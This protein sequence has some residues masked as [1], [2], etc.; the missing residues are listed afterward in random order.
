MRLPA[1]G[2]ALNKQTDCCHVADSLAA[3]LPPA[4]GLRNRRTCHYRG[5]HR[6]S[7]P[8]RHRLA[9]CG[10]AADPRRIGNC[11]YF[12]VAVAARI[13]HIGSRGRADMSPLPLRTRSAYTDSPAR[14]DHSRG[15]CSPGHAFQGGVRYELHVQRGRGT[16][17]GRGVEYLQQPLPACTATAHTCNLS[18]EA[19][20]SRGIRSPGH[21]L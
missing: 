14:E 17:V 8:C 19:V 21:A 10:H 11:F 15:T 7:H 3:K 6:H 20:R 2:N 1:A 4:A 13:H 9:S 18:H 16:P 12:A 5:R